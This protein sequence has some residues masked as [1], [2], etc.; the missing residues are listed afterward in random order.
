MSM[1]VFVLLLIKTGS[2]QNKNLHTQINIHIF[3][4]LHFRSPRHF[5]PCKVTE[6]NRQKSTEII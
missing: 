6:S 2:V 5:A 3:K 1:Y 4:I